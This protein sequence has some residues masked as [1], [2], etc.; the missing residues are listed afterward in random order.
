MFLQIVRKGLKWLGRFAL[1]LFVFLVMYFLLT[2][3]LPKIPVAAEQ[4]KDAKNIPIYILSNGVHTDLVVPIKTKHKDWSKHISFANTKSKDT[5]FSYLA[6][7]W[8]DKGFYLETPTWDQL[9]FS[10]AFNASFGLSTTAIHTTFYK[11]MQAND[12]NCIRI[13]LTDKQYKRLIS[14]IHNSFQKSGDE[15]YL[16]IPTNA[17]YGVNDAF[18][19]AN[20]NYNLFQTCNCWTNNGLKSCGQKACLWTPFATG[21]FDQYRKD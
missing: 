17:V 10:T 3:I 14:Y 21:I 6:M 2:I 13:D 15:H 9:K 5:S 16:F 11:D 19:E 4:T 7:G 20:G 12:T 1:T 8:G 18:Y